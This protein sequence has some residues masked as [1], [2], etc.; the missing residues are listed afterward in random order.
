MKVTDALNP[1]NQGISS[2]SAAPCAE[3]A[4]GLLGAALDPQHLRFS[5]PPDVVI[6]AARVGEALH[7]PD[8][9]RGDVAPAAVRAP[10]E[11]ALGQAGL[12]RELGG[13]GRR[14]PNV[15]TEAGAR[16]L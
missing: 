7:W 4:E 1:T 15:F 9:V 16:T 12:R 5:K 13:A 3:E 14:A 8:S 2:G 11:R 6:C 10:L